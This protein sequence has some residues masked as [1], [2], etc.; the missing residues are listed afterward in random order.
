[1]TRAAISEP[2]APSQEASRLDRAYR[3]YR[4]YTKRCRTENQLN[5]VHIA[6]DNYM[7]PAEVRHFA[8]AL[9][10]EPA[11]SPSRR[12]IDTLERS[13]PVKAPRPL[14]FERRE[15]A[16]GVTHYTAGASPAA[17]KTLIIGFSGIHH[18]LMMPTAWLLDCLNPQLYDVVVLRDFSRRSF[19]LGLP[20]LG[21]DL[22][23]LLSGLRKHCDPRAYRKAVSMGTSAGGVP[24]VIAAIALGL[25]RGI[26]VCPS[27]YLWYVQ[28]L[29]AL[30]LN[31]RAYAE[32]LA[33]RNRP[34]PQ[35]VLVT[36]A[37]K[38]DDLAAAAALHAVVPSRLWK[39][40][41]CAQH[42]VLKWQI[43]RGTLRPFLSKLLD[44]SLEASDP[45]GAPLTAQWV[46]RSSGSLPL[47]ATGVPHATDS[48]SSG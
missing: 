1:M 18:R 4:R 36:G 39:L 33:S 11:N 25:D 16:R 22:L 6:L 48:V 15:H 7:T 9:A 37:E 42:G 10:A 28:H 31:E 29:K 20:G 13:M 30:G 14:E 27:H 35:L 19:A 46:I 5:R 23:G 44:Q 2:N 38:K 34:F 8:A 24:A 41:N 32:V 3:L 40:R 45:Q 26:A 47:R 43:E 17:Q 21:S 12:W